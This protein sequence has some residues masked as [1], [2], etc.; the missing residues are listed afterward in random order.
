M[1]RK[2]RT[3]ISVNDGAPARSLVPKHLTKQ[4]FGRR[5][6]QLMISRG[7]HQSELSRRSGI[8]R[9]AISTYVRGRSMPTPLNLERLAKAFDTS[10]DE[11]LPNYVE[12][13]IED[14][15]PAV[16]MKVSSNAPNMAWLRVN[17]LVS[18]ATA[19]KIVELLG[20]DDAFNRT[21]SGP[22]SAL[23]HVED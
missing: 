14:D 2:T 3:H 15:S 20:A 17:R 18:T 1:V 16:E 5:V 8:P 10:A 6:Y 22:S 9:D 11:L 12:S 23:Q 7:W 13:A 21:R 4:E 19:V